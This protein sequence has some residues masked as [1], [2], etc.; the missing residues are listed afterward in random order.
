MKLSIFGDI[1]LYNINHN[2]F[3]FCGNLH[4]LLNES[5]LNV[6]NLECPITLNQEKD[7][8]LAVTM[9]AYGESLS[10]L[11]KFDVFS[12]ANNHI[13]D[14]KDQ[15]VTDT[16]IVL[17]K[18]GFHYFGVGMMQKEALAPY[19]MEQGDFKIAFIGATRFANTSGSFLG[20]GNDSSSIISQQIK[21]LK[22]NGYFVA[23]FPHWGYEYVRIPSPRERNL[24]HHWI[25]AGADIVVGSHPHIYQTIEEYKGKRIVYSLGNFIF[26]SSVFDG[27]SYISNDPRLQESFVLSVDIE[28]DYSY[29]TA[30]HGYRTTDDGVVLHSKLENDKLIEEITELSKVMLLPKTKYL[31]A[32]YRQAY[33]ISKQNAKVRNEFQNYEQQTL[34]Q[35]IRFYRNA[36]IQD[37]KN[38]LAG[39][40]YSL[41]NKS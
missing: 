27:L 16:F 30:T 32:Y 11:D 22:Q 12:L 2:Q 36:N 26:H 5:D 20:T 23:I 14:F 9:Y 40:V 13:R 7:D 35:K 15:G 39:L 10:I 4:Q 33:E 25:D 8:S 19:L 18:I 38:K 6:G 37:V 3:R 31:K 34:M 29:K 24:A 21:K 41:L 17:Q 28:K 1:S